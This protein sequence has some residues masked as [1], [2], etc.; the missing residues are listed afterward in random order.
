AWRW[1]GR[2]WCR[3]RPWRGSKHGRDRSCWGRTARRRGWRRWCGCSGT[4][5]GGG[6]G[7]GGGGRAVWGGARGAGGWGALGGGPGRG[8]WGAAGSS[9]SDAG[10]AADSF[11][12]IPPDLPWWNVAERQVVAGPAHSARPAG[13][14]EGRVLPA[15]DRLKLLA[16]P[17]VLAQVR[18]RDQ[19]VAD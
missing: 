3:R 19:E 13:R 14:H 4:R 12:S 6:G 2:R 11:T 8:G 7:G 18:V 10:P 5:G 16:L 1:V 9:A 15:R 17:G